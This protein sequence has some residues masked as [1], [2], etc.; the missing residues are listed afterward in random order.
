MEQLAK[1]FANAKLYSGP[2]VQHFLAENAFTVTNISNLADF[3]V[4]APSLE[5]QVYEASPTEI[6][7]EY[8]ATTKH[9]IK[10]NIAG[11]PGGGEIARFE[12]NKQDIRLA[13]P[14]T[15]EK[16]KEYAKRVDAMVV[17]LTTMS[18]DNSATL[19]QT[20]VLLEGMFREA[21]LTAP[22]TSALSERIYDALT[23]ARTNVDHQIQGLR[24]SS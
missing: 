20:D 2:V 5:Y 18:G 16:Y 3:E 23:T 1:S 15:S 12:V 8:V 24:E 7:V 9:L 22:Q 6:R 14:E 17:L 19:A 4:V 13:V 21:A 11:W 10:L